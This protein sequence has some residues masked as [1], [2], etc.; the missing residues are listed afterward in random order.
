MD[1]QQQVEVTPGYISQTNHL[2]STKNLMI[3]H[4]WGLHVPWASQV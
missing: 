3:S 1:M 2:T 4:S